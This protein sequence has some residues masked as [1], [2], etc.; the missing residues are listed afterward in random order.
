MK[1]TIDI[2]ASLLRCA[3]RVAARD[4]TTLRAL[5]EEGLRRVLAERDKNRRFRARNAS[6]EGKGLRPELEG[7]AWERIRDASYKGRGG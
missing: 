3:R 7:A 2:A 6:F 4:G 5:F 1:T